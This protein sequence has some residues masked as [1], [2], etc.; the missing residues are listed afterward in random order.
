MGNQRKLYVVYHEDTNN[1]DMK[2]L[3]STLK[4]IKG[5]L[6]ISLSIP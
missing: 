5:D 3:N 1:H 4:E 2:K 6:E